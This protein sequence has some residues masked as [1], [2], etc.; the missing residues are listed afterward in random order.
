MSKHDPHPFEWSSS[1]VKGT[2]WNPWKDISLELHSFPLLVYYGVGKATNVFFWGDQWVGFDHPTLS[3]LV[4]YHCLLLE[5]VWFKIFDFVEEFNFFLVW[6][7]SC[8]DR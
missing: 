7:R 6:L 5:I 2:F 3:F 8:V 4:L 1:G